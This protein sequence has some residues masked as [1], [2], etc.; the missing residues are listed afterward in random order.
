LVQFLYWDNMKV[1]K[2]TT[3]LSFILVL[4]LSA[5]SNTQQAYKQNILLMLASNQDASLSNETVLTSPLDLIYIKNGDRPASTMGLAFIENGLYKWL[6]RD[7]VMIITANG[8]LYRTIGLANNLLY[9]SN[10]KQDP[11]LQVSSTNNVANTNNSDGAWSRLIDVEIAG[12][13]DF[14]VLL[15]SESKVVENVTLVIQGIEFMVFKVQ[16]TVSATSVI[17]GKYEWENT[18]WYDAGTKQ[19][20]QSSQIMAANT[21]RIEIT[22]VSRALRLLDNSNLGAD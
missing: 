20:L 15:E 4:F 12:Q 7:N 6:S 11:L 16:E 17:Q 18:F 8:R 10:V 22:Y 13:G 5:C 3:L 2:Q 14:G 19:L 21:D 1:C 9:T